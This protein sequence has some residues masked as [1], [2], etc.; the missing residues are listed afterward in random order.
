MVNAGAVQVERHRPRVRERVVQKQ[1]QRQ[2]GARGRGIFGPV[3]DRLAPPVRVAQ[4]TEE[5]GSE[6]VGR[7]RHHP[8]Q[9]ILVVTRRQP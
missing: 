1:S 5:I 6:I 8:S 4:A 9:T 7:H 2:R 3:E